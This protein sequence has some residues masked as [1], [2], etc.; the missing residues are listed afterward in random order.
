MKKK[1]IVIL[2]LFFSLLGVKADEYV[3][4]ILVDGT[5][6]KGFKS[7]VLEYNLDVDSQKETIK[8]VFVYDK[9][10]YKGSGSSENIKLVP[11]LNKVTYTIKD[12]DLKELATYV[13]N[14]KKEDNRSSDNSLSS[15]R[16]GTNQVVLSDKNEYDVYVDSKL[17]KVE[18]K[19]TLKDN[20]S[21]FVSGY[22]ER[23]GNNSITLS[24]ETT[25]VEV[26]VSAENESIRTYLI[27]IIKKDYKSSD[28]TLKELKI[29]KI[30]FTFKSD[31]LEYNLTVKNNITSINIDATSNDSKA[32]LT[33]DKTIGLKE[34]INNLIIK[35]EAEDGSS[36]EYKINITREQE[37]KLVKDITITDVDFKFDSSK[38]NYILKTDLDKLDIKVTLT[39]EDAKVEILDNEN[40][41]NNSKITLKVTLDEKE[42]TYNFKIVKDDTKDDV[43]DETKDENKS[44][45]LNSFLKTN[46]MLI[47]VGV[48]GLGV[49]SLLIAI[50]DKKRRV[51]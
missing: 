14:I 13:V 17:T 15:L 1:L 31:T 3:T 16:I 49:L 41:Q 22:G 8:V 47:G 5:S 38:T 18:L 42:E 12:M 50:I 51:K 19:A 24:G 36:L 40:L 21:K 43:K 23:I 10:K 7:E 20:K 37:E 26:K 27:N 44:F 39:K 46:E 35:V 25:K 2:F 32:T 34:G 6:L 33:Y 48:F 30:P 11:G 45:D 28:A 4:D 9:T 29:D